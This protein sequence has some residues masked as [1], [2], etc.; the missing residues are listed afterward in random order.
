MRMLIKKRGSGKTT[1]LIYASEATGFRIITPTSS[2]AKYIKTQAE[3][4]GCVIP[5]PMP[6]NKYIE[7]KD[8][9]HDKG[10]FLD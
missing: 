1:E 6:Y 9:Y 5:E 3:K 4:L 8:M 7:M 2:M 10:V